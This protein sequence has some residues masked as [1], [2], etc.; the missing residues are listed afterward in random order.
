MEN[1]KIFVKLTVSFLI[2]AMMAMVVGL[3]GV[4][5]VRTEYKNI[6]QMQVQTSRLVENTIYADAFNKLAGEQEEEFLTLTKIIISILVFV[7]T[8]VVISAILFGYYISDIISR[9]INSCIERIKKILIEGDLHSPV[10]I[11]ETKDECG[12]L[13][14]EVRYLTVTLNNIINEQSVMLKAM[15]KGN[16]TQEHEVEYIGDFQPLKVSNQMLQVALS[17][18]WSTLIRRTNHMDIVASVSSLTYWEFTVTTDALELSLHFWD[19]FGYAPGEINAMGFNRDV[20]YPPS[21][22]ID[23]IHPDDLNRTIQELNDYISGIADN[24]RSELQIRHKNGHYMWVVMSGRTMEWDNGKPLLM[25]GGISNIDDVKKSESA[26]SAKSRFLATMSHEIRTPMNAIIGMSELIR[27][28]N[29]DRQQLDFFNDIRTMSH[30]LLQ[31]INDILDISKIEAG[32]FDLLPVHFDLYK[33]YNSVSN[34]NKFMAGSKNLEFRTSIDNDVPRV[35][36]GDDIRVRQII[37]NLLNNAVKYTQEGLVQF[38]VRNVHGKDE[39]YVAFIVEDTGIGIKHENISRIFGTFEQIDRHKNRGIAG[40]GLG[41][42]ICKLLTEMMNGSIMVES[43]YGKGSVFTVYLPLPKGDPSQILQSVEE[44]KVISKGDVKVLVVDDSP[45]NLKVAVAYLATHHI[46]AETA[47]SGM[48]ALHKIEDKRYNIIF[49]DHMMP[50]MD[51]LET[52]GRIRAMESEWC[53][54]VPIIALTANAVSGTRELFLENGMNDFLS[55]PINSAELN[56]VLGQ[57]LPQDMYT[58]SQSKAARTPFRTANPEDTVINRAMGIANAANS[59]SFY[60]QLLADFKLNHEND[61]KK[62]KKMIENK[63]YLAA[64]RTAHTLKNTAALIGANALASAALSMEDALA[65]GASFIDEG[66]K[67]ENDLWNNLENQC[68]AVFLAISVPTIKEKERES[69]IFIDRTQMLAFINRL[70][71]LL[72]VNSAKSLDLLEDLQEILAPA[73]GGYEELA[74]RIES[75]DFPEA[76]NLLIGIKEKLAA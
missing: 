63:D 54:T 7:M 6:Q 66:H 38:F 57:W 8:T 4:V 55:K 28:D 37:T 9:P 3:A 44:K 48:E 35:V 42:P 33:L 76:L 36:Y 22:W 5:A 45:I 27:T 40:T 29:L 60:E 11:F 52:T 18:N 2:V 19:Q 56:R 75:F 58:I 41:L 73:E 25:I 72:R 59:E 65:A 46:Q 53:K 49:M 31:I 14:R 26:N 51:G 10:E 64:R 15:A 23:I 69:S 24:Y 68:N 1:L 20:S 47:G 34:Q 32:K 50:E 71:A 67:G 21:K 39:D 16:Y 61:L 30:M 17:T 43:E 12:E 70:E 62:I 13:S 74:R